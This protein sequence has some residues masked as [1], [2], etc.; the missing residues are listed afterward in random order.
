[1]TSLVKSFTS[2]SDQFEIIV[3]QRFANSAASWN[4]PSIND[5]LALHF[6]AKDE[7]NVKL[8][9]NLKESIKRLSI[10]NKNINLHNEQLSAENLKLKESNKV[11]EK[12]VYDLQVHNADLLATK[13][14]VEAVKSQLEKELKSTAQTESQIGVSFAGLL[15]TSINRFVFGDKD[16]DN[17]ANNA[18]VIER[19]DLETFKSTQYHWPAWEERNGQWC[20]AYNKHPPSYNGGLKAGQIQPVPWLEFP[21]VVRDEYNQF[22]IEP[23]KDLIVRYRTRLYR[24]TPKY[25]TWR[26]GEGADCQ[27]TLASIG[28]LDRLPT[29]AQTTRV[30][31]G[32]V[33]LAIWVP[34][35]EEITEK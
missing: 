8:F 27:I 20:A 32:R 30:W 15:P 6:Q 19:L 13:M 4:D 7:N 2:T 3:N 12:S 34:S 21:K 11:L 16:S 31:R 10:V 25:P 26:E 17:V 33:S 18:V 35:K 23:H 29:L 1:M 5:D 24:I 22:T 14:E 28:S 9:V